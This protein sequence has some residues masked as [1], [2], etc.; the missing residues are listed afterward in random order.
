M[1]ALDDALRVIASL[2][3]AGVDYVVVGGVAVNLHGLVRATED[4]DLFIRPDPENVARLRD[5]LAHVWEDPSIAEITADDLCGDYPAVRYGPP[6]GSLYLDILARLG[7]ATRYSDLEVE[8]KRVGDLVVRV[9]TPRT[10]YRMKRGT[11]R[12]I[13]HADAEALRAA[14]DS[15]GRLT[16][17]CPDIAPSRTCR[18]P[19]EW[20]TPPPCC[21]AFGPSGGA[22]PC[23]HLRRWWRAA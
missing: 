1:D 17:P 15:R 9:A 16:C 4:L 10:L 12:P 8:E 14:F 11:V 3:E 18:A 22:P 13:D 5:A 21:H 7:E 19:S 20:P 2:N 6:E 23:S